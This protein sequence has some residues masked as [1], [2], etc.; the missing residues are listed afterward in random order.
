MV[1]GHLE[2]VSHLFVDI[3]DDKFLV[4]F[5]ENELPLW[6][7][8]TF[9]LDNLVVHASRHLLKIRKKS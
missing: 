5:D 3:A 1:Q 7:V 4:A 9:Q 2:R 6:P 8:L